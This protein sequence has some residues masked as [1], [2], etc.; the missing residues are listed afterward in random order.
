[1]QA[2]HFS[3]QGDPC[4]TAHYAKSF[5]NTAEACRKDCPDGFITQRFTAR[6]LRNVQWLYKS[7]MELCTGTPSS[8]TGM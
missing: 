1:V 8:P 4:A 7:G 3:I 2:R 5:L 6:T